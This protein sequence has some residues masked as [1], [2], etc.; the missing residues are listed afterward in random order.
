[1]ASAKA[2]A[3]FFR[4]CHPLRVFSVATFVPEFVRGF[5]VAMAAAVE[6]E[7]HQPAANDQGEEHPEAEGNPAVRTDLYAAAGIPY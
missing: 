5:V 6:H 3:S 1:M 4:S 2:G 7:R